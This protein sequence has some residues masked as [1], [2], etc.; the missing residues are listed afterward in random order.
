MPYY[1]TNAPVAWVAHT[2]PAREDAPTELK[3]L[4]AT[5][6]GMEIDA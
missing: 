3:G 6:A 5:A 4:N 2:L 1:L